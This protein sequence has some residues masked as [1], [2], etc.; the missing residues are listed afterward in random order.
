MQAHAFYDTAMYTN[1][2]QHDVK[3][4]KLINKSNT[5][6]EKQKERVE[7]IIWNVQ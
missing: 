3:K 2:R 4:A 7:T 1:Y 5:Q 6:H